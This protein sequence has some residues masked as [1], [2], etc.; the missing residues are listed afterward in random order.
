M[1]VAAA[2]RYGQMVAL[3]APSLAARSHLGGDVSAAAALPAADAESRAPRVA[4]AASRRAGCVS[5][6]CP[7]PWG[8][9][10]GN[11]PGLPD[12]PGWMASMVRKPSLS[13]HFAGR[14]LAPLTPFARPTLPMRS[15]RSSHPRAHLAPVGAWVPPTLESLGASVQLTCKARRGRGQTMGGIGR[16]LLLCSLRSPFLTED[17]K[18]LLRTSVL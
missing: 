5:R 15:S 7:D 14:V 6:A 4:N 9:R 10:E 1:R 13:G 2:S 8:P 12:Q 18:R 3:V 16:G 11:D 17:P